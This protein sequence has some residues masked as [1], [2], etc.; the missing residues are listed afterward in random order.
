M[1]AI[2][3]Y[4]EQDVANKEQQLVQM[5]KAAEA[6]QQTLSTKEAQIAEKESYNF[7]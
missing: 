7:V 5:T 2:R 1:Y 4:Y 3:S 6:L